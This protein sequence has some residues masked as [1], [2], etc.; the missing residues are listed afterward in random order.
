MAQMAV[1]GGH[2]EVKVHRAAF[3]LA[4]QLGDQRRAGRGLIG[5]DQHAPRGQRGDACARAVTVYGNGVRHGEIL[6]VEGLC[7]SGGRASV[8]CSGPVLPK[9]PEPTNSFP[10]V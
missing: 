10:I 1:E 7:G 8:A 3:G 5:D 4:S 6:P 9:T 2:D